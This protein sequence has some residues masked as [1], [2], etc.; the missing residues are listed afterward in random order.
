MTI[1]KLNSLRNLVAVAK[2]E[3]ERYAKLESVADYSK[4]LEEN[5]NELDKALSSTILPDFYKVAVV[6]RFKV[7]KSSF[8]NAFTNSKIAVVS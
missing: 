7:G 8:V 4:L 1:A 5:I 6:G 2:S 3:L